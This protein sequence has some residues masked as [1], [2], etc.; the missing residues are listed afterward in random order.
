MSGTGLLIDDPHR[1]ENDLMDR[2]LANDATR[3]RGPEG[4]SGRHTLAAGR[5]L[6][7]LWATT[8]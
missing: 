2:L 8:E 4:G 5:R 7:L 6:S 1:L 3:V